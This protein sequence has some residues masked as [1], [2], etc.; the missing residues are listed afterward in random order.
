MKRKG[1]FLEV[2]S[3]VNTEKKIHTHL[4]YPS[5]IEKNLKELYFSQVMLFNGDNIVVVKVIVGL[6]LKGT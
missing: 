2:E 5:I 4:C 6:H 1:T 3:N